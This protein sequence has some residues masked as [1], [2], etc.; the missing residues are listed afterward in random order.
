MAQGFPGCAFEPD[1][2]FRAERRKTLL[3]QRRGV[4]ALVFVEMGKA[5]ERVMAFNPDRGTRVGRSYAN[6]RG[7]GCPGVTDILKVAA[8]EPLGVSIG[9]FRVWNDCDD[10]IVQFGHL[11]G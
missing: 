5:G 6:R 11:Q 2:R 9:K 10:P 3:S 8:N 7:R 1:A 4:Q